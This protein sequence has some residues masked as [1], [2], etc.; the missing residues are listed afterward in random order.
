AAAAEQGKE[1]LVLQ[2]PGAG[3]FQFQQRVLPGVHVHGVYVAGP[4]EGVIEGVATGGR[5][6][7]H[8][9]L[10]GQLQ[11][12]AI[13]P[14][15]FHALV[16]KYVPPVNDIDPRFAESFDAHLRPRRGDRRLGTR[17]RGWSSTDGRHARTP[18]PRRVV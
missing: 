11:R 3:E 17:G 14:R 6:D 2:R 12:D 8:A 7:D 4:G 15:I 1:I 18:V 5:D 16:V 10:I 13:H 9:V